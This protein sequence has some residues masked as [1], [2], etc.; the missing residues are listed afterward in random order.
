MATCP[1]IRYALQES[2][3]Y[4]ALLVIIYYL[5]LYFVLKAYPYSLIDFLTFVVEGLSVSLPLESGCAI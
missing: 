4:L 5:S 2:S 1:K 3:N